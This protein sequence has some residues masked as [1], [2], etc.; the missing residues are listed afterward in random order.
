MSGMKH[1]RGWASD[2]WL[3]VRGYH[4]DPSFGP[5]WHYVQLATEAETKRAAELVMQLENESAT[6]PLRRLLWRNELRELLNKKAVI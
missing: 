3:L 2:N 4:R 6:N 1:L 5:E